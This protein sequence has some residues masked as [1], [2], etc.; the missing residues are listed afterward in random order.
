MAKNRASGRLTPDPLD[1]LLPRNVHYSEK[2]TCRKRD[3]TF[4]GLRIAVLSSECL[5]FVSFVHGTHYAINF[6]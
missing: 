5:G 3:E 4:L 6:M 2:I 1:A